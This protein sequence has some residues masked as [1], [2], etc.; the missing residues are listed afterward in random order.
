M[1]RVAVVGGGISGLSSAYRILTDFKS[2]LELT[3]ISE[4]SYENTTSR[5]AAGLWRPDEKYDSDDETMQT[6]KRWFRETREYYESLVA[7][8]IDFERG[9]SMSFLIKAEVIDN[10]S[11]ELFRDIVP[12]T[13]KLNVENIQRLFPHAKLPGDINHALLSSIFMCRPRIYMPWMIKEIEK[14]GGKF[15][16]GTRINSFQDLITDYDIV[17]NCSAMSAKTLLNDDLMVP[18]RGQVTV[19]RAPWVSFGIQ[20]NFSSYVLP[21]TDGTVTLGGCYQEGNED[22]SVDYDLKETYLQSCYEFVPSLKKAEFIEDMVGLRPLRKGG[23]RVELQLWTPSSPSN[24]GDASDSRLPIIHNYG[25]GPE[26]WGLHWGTSGDVL[27]IFTE[28]MKSQ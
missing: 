4:H 23:P 10:P 14:M 22:L 12:V 21:G 24:E 5:V 13:H 19:V 6:I 25:H 16:I 15:Q 28:W 27:K 26:G 7:E 1:V 11:S 2:E 18:V 9:V 8:G 20:V 3:I 17:I